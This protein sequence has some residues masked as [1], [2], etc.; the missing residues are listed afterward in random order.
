MLALPYCIS[1]LGGVKTFPNRSPNWPCWSHVGA[2]LPLFSLL[3][4]FW[5]FLAAFCASC[6][7]LLSLLVGFF[8]FG[9]ALGSILEGSRGFQGGFGKLLELIFRGFLVHRND[10]ARKTSIL[11][12]PLKTSTGAIKFK[13][14][15]LTPY[16]KIDQKTEKTRTEGLSNP[17]VDEGRNKNWPWGSPGSILQPLGRLLDVPWAS[18]GRSWAPLGHSWALLGRLWALLGRFLDALWRLLGASWASWV[19]FDRFW[20]L[21]KAFQEGLEG[22]RRKI[23][24]HVF[25]ASAG[26]I[27]CGRNPYSF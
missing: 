13:V 23:F 11:E 10:I 5:A 12:K 1:Y 14:R 4:V 20:I 15:A 26:C 22:L 9:I 16:A 17:A 21:L 25:R 19:I 2:M 6:C 24:G 18:L 27:N 3:G 8:S 7:V